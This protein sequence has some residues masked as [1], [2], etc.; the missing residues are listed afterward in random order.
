MLNVHSTVFFNEANNEMYNGHSEIWTLKW[1]LIPRKR[2][3]SEI[4][5]YRFSH[6]KN[7]TISG[8]LSYFKEI[9]GMLIIKI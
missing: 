5:N 6:L 8:M 7:Q 2:Q 1:N 9:I 4:I 3:K